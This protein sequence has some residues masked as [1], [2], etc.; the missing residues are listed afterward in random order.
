L[1]QHD[2]A[3][4]ADTT[5]LEADAEAR[6]PGG[7]GAYPRSLSRRAYPSSCFGRRTGYI[8]WFQL[9]PHADLVGRRVDDLP[10]AGAGGTASVVSMDDYHHIDLS[11]GTVPAQVGGQLKQVAPGT[12]ARPSVVV[13]LNGVIGGVSETFAAGGKS[14]TWFT[15]M[16]PD[17]SCTRVTTICSSSCW[18]PPVVSS[19]S[20]R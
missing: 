17:T 2:I 7:P 10:M 9:G 20:A 15:A 11:S 19:A 14:P 18:T 13:A 4:R 16:V 12:P 1:T 3:Y 6:G 8:G 5:Q